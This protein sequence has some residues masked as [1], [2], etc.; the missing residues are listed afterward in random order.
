MQQQLV[1]GR[2]RL[3]RTVGSGG[4]GRVWLARDEM[5][6][7]DVAIKEVVPPD[8]MTEQERDDLR[9][10]TLREA[11]S[12]ARLNHPH[13][14]QIY[15]VVHAGPT[16]WIVMEYVRSRSV[17]EIIASDGPFPPERT[18]EI[19]LAVL[20]ALRAAHSAGVLHRDVKPHNVLIAD[21]GRVVLTDFGLATVDGG[22]GAM[23]RAGV[24]LGS[25]QYVAPERA[26]EGASTVEADLW[27]LGATLYAAVEGRSP[28]HRPTTMATLTALAVAPPDPAQRAG[29]LRPVLAGL[30]RRDPAAR[31]TAVEAERLLRRV[32]EPAP[33]GRRHRRAWRLVAAA[34]AAAVVLGA[35]GA[36]LVANQRRQGGPAAGPT[37]SG[38]GGIAAAP[39]FPCT[40]APADTAEVTP[41]AV[42]PDEPYG[43]VRGWT[44][45]VDP[46]GFRIAAPVGWRHYT[47]GGAVCF[48]EPGG[49]RVLAVDPGTPPAPDPV[50]YLRAEEARLT[51]GGA[52]PGYEQVSIAPLEMYQGGA[53]WECGW[54][55][56]A[57]QRVRT[58]R[59]VVN[60]SARQAYTVSWLTP[61]FDWQVNRAYL[62]MIRQSFRPAL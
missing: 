23:T 48:R 35:A 56:P 47:D 44:W 24:V 30:L 15:D 27:S 55:N 59:M 39:A 22:D 2:Y 34:T 9:I 16:P 21:D 28:Y 45:H 3:L 53:E 49:G 51:D 58:W 52:L 12:A 62:P 6:R 38:Q 29:P 7:R 60:T 8:W 61:E 50:G 46:A 57:G 25:P 18:A 41:T 20:A 4:M 33:P 10:S 1:A 19:G 42:P 26:A 14:V 40:R 36:G 32:V 13:V 31:L 54:T 11:R 17:Q 37:P 43:L 5:L